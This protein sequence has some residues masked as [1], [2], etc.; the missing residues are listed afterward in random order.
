[1]GNILCPP[2]RPQ[3]P[4]DPRFDYYQGHGQRTTADTSQPVGADGK[5]VLLPKQINNLPIEEYATAS[6]M[7]EWRVSQLKDEL[8]RA[9]VNS[10]AD[11]SNR[12]DAPMPLEKAELVNAVVA[13]RGGDSGQTCSVCFDAFESGD[14]L[15]VLPCGHR[16][17][18]EC[19]D[20]WLRSQS[21]TCPIC[22][23]DATKTF[24]QGLR[25]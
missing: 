9:R 3:R 8:R 21:L 23:H 7:L 15:R 14:G 16:F 1:M 25:A 20:K 10:P 24:R 18:I 12:D 19:I 11:R 6:E 13:A 22:K 4:Y 2:T 17:H 5:P